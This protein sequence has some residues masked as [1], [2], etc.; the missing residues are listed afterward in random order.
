MPDASWY[1]ATGQ[2]QARGIEALYGP[3][4]RIL[5][6]QVGRRSGTVVDFFGGP[7][8]LEQVIA[9]MQADRGATLPPGL[10]AVWNRTGRPEIIAPPAL[11][12]STVSHAVKVETGGLIDALAAALSQ[13]TRSDGG[14]T[15][16]VLPDGRVLAEVVTAEQTRMDHRRRVQAG[17][18]GWRPSVHS[19]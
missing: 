15:Y 17:S 12:A 16:L 3:P 7:G 11:L 8:G 1:Q 18:A 4:E 5:P 19:T 9:M 6:S 2:G 14:A 13:A 10:S